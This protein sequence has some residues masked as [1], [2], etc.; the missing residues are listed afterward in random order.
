M[1]PDLPDL[2][3]VFTRI[4]LMSFGGA[5]RHCIARS[6]VHRAGIFPGALCV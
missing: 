5:A 1:T 4:G 3:R 2:I 6:L